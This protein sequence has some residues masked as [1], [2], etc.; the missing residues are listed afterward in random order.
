L[1][2]K[3]YAII[4]Y[5]ICQNEHVNVHMLFLLENPGCKSVHTMGNSKVTESK[6]RDISAGVSVSDLTSKQTPQRKGN[7]TPHTIQ[8]R[9]PHEEKNYA[10]EGFLHA[11]SQR[12]TSTC[13]VVHIKHAQRQHYKSIPNTHYISRRQLY[14]DGTE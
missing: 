9:K 11:T 14:A 3:I 10:T 7:I 2:L 1:K 8:Q 12:V 4:K 5:G 6:Q 13:A